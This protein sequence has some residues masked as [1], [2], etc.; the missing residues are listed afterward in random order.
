[1]KRPRNKLV[2]LW[3]YRNSST[4]PRRYVDKQTRTTTENALAHSVTLDW[5]Q[6]FLYHVLVAYS[7]FL[8][9]RIKSVRSF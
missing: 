2:T 7:V 6:Q 1:M 3:G 9:L 8:V 4:K 5:A